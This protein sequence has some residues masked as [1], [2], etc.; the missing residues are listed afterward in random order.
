MLKTYLDESNQ[1]F[2]RVGGWGRKTP[3]ITRNFNIFSKK[4]HF[5]SSD[6]IIL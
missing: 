6:I 2:R 4:L 1:E 3:G 5:I